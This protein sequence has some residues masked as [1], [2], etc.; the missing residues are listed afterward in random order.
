MA[1][2]SYELPVDFTVTKASASEVK[3]TEKL[4]KKMKER[5]PQK[6]KKCRY[7]P[8]D[9]GYD[10]TDLIEW[11]VAAYQGLIHLFSPLFLVAHALSHGE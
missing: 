10:S 3:E 8:A 6:I 4:L 11:P 9:C 1:D 7:F 2:A 5:K